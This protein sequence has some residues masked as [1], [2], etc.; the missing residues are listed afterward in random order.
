MRALL[1]SVQPSLTIHSLW[2]ESFH[3]LWNMLEDRVSTLPFFFLEEQDVQIWCFYTQGMTLIKKKKKTPTWT[4]WS[5]IISQT[6]D[7]HFLH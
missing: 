2:S 3:V 4:T 5:P 1:P 7:K 6:S